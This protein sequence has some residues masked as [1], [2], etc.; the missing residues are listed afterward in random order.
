MRDLLAIDSLCVDFSRGS[1]T[2]FGSRR[3]FRALDNVSLT[4]GEGECLG[5]VGESGSGKSTLGA[6]ILG[7]ATPSRGRIH[8]DGREIAGLPRDRNPEIAKAI[9]IVFQDPSGSLDPHM[10]IWQSVAE[11]LEIHSAMHRAERRDAATALLD[12]VGIDSAMIDRFP[13]AL[14]GGQRQRVAIARTLATQPRLIVLDEP[15]SALDMTVQ[16]QVLDLLLDIQERTRVSYLLITH[17]MAVAGHMC[18][19][20]A[21]LRAGRIEEIGDARRIVSE[22]ETEYARALVNATPRLAV[23]GVSL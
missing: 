23:D 17:D 2:P 20:I 1:K 19:R 7:L 8:F 9:Q 14:S 15:T 6:C 12:S 13:H 16:A 4:L 22:P 18:H 3:T 5:L 21:V 11:S 10:P